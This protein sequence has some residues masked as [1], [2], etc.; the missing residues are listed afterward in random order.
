[1]LNPENPY[2]VFLEPSSLQRAQERDNARDR[3]NAGETRAV[4][5]AGNGHS[6]SH[7]WL[8]RLIERKLRG[9]VR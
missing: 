9:D 1:M 8:V 3:D 5:G 4:H 2:R 6:G 7:D